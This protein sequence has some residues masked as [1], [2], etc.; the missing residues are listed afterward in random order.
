M[1]PAMYRGGYNACATQVLKL[2][3]LPD[4]GCCVLTCTQDGAATLGWQLWALPQLWRASFFRSA[5]SSASW[6]LAHNRGND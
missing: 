1:G 6:S 4:S 5:V 2:Y 3:A